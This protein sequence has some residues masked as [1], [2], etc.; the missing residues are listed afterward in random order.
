MTDEI[1]TED[2]EA[3]DIPAQPKIREARKG[4]G[5]GS[6]LFCSGAAA[7]IGVFGSQFVS[8]VQTGASSAAGSENIADIQAS[9]EKSVKTLTAKLDRLENKL[10]KI[11]DGGSTSTPAIDNQAV[12]DLEDRLADL[13]DKLGQAAEAPNVSKVDP[14]LTNRIETL[15][16][17]AFEPES[18]EGLQ[19]IQTRITELDTR[20]TEISQASDTDAVETVDLSPL[21]DRLTALET[22]LDER[23]EV[24]EAREAPELPVIDLS[25]VETRL[26][27]VEERLDSIPVTLPA[28]PRQAVL[29]AIEASKEDAGKGG[30]LSRT[31]S[32]QVT[33]Q[34]ADLLARLDRIESNVALQDVDAVRQD[35][36][37]LPDAAQD[38]LK[39]WMTKIE[40]VGK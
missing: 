31:L 8:G 37:S 18:L 15:E 22:G 9:T 12:S 29:D 32:G 30:W 23:L 1:D 17:A 2:V 6:V 5:L 39:P 34:D 35:V 21:E 25:P 3:E 11:D 40:S 7:L 20:L 38:A 13:E 16:K 19:D 28:F 26:D 36:L 33:V 14:E 4:A 27:A 10:A 24:L